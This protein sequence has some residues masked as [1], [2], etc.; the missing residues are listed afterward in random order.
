[1]GKGVKNPQTYLYITG[2]K[3]ASYHLR[4][5]KYLS[6]VDGISTEDIQKPSTSDISS[7]GTDNSNIPA[8]LVHLARLQLTTCRL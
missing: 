7:A 5:S 1:M 6:E 3:Y 8:Y 4:Y 2:G